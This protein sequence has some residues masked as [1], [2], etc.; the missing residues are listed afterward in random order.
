[1]PSLKYLE[2]LNPTKNRMNQAPPIRRGAGCPYFIPQPCGAGASLD[3]RLVPAAVSLSLLP[4]GPGM[5]WCCVYTG[6]YWWKQ[7]VEACGT[8]SSGGLWEGAWDF[9]RSSS[10][11]WLELTRSL[12]S[13]IYLGVTPAQELILCLLQPEVAWDTYYCLSR[14][15]WFSNLNQMPTKQGFSL[16]SCQDFSHCNSFIWNFH[17]FNFSSPKWNL[18]PNTLFVPLNCF[19]VNSSLQ[20]Y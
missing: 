3:T 11:S 5:G 2:A 9:P 6:W 1:M 18:L 19:A 17:R 15:G 12:L 16:S 10:S 4:A 14:H 20:F 7:T 8:S 13:R